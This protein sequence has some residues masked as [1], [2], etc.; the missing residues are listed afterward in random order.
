MTQTIFLTIQDS[1]AKLQAIC[2]T[3]QKHFYL[4]EKILLL[5]PNDEAA[6]YI[7]QLLWKLPEESF[8]P[9]AVI[10]SPAQDRVAISK[11]RANLTQAAVLFNLRSEA[12]VGIPGPHTMIYDLLDHSHPTKLQLSLERQKVYEQAV[13]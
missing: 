2:D 7:D 9:H 8:I 4:S 3:V 12:A 13:V 1:A 6:H 11:I 10:A 5:V